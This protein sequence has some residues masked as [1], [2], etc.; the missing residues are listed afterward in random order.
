MDLF[1]Q[2]KSTSSCVSMQQSEQV[3]AMLLAFAER[4]SAKAISLYY[5]RTMNKQHFW[6]KHVL[7]SNQ[8]YKDEVT[9][10]WAY[11]SKMHKGLFFSPQ[12]SQGEIRGGRERIVFCQPKSEFCGSFA[13]TRK[14]KS[15]SL[16]HSISLSGYLTVKLM[17]TVFKEWSQN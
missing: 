9:C 5:R 2:E 4:L 15:V 11:Q 16:G 3:S 14:I 6:I 7:L 8:P 13:E 10:R 12:W 1:C 17:T